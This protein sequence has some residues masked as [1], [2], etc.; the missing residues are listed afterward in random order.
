MAR[1]L[2]LQNWGGRV[3][4]RGM[5]AVMC[6]RRG[7]RLVDMLPLLRRFGVQAVAMHPGVD[8]PALALWHVLNGPDEQSLRQAVAALQSH[9]GVDAALVKPSGE[10]PLD[11]APG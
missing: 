4:A 10:A 5:E 7:V 6:L 9:P 11:G 8:D 3:Y 1:G 2:A